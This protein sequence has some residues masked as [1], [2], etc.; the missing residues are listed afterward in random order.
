VVVWKLS[1]GADGSASD[2]DVVPVQTRCARECEASVDLGNDLPVFVNDIIAYSRAREQINALNA[3]LLNGD[4]YP[5]DGELVA[6]GGADVV[7]ALQHNP[8]LRNP[9]MT[10]ILDRVNAVGL[11]RHVDIARHQDQVVVGVPSVDIVVTSHVAATAPLNVNTPK[12]PLCPEV[13]DDPRD[14][15]FDTL[16]LHVAGHVW[17]HI[18]ENARNEVKARLPLGNDDLQSLRTRQR[19]V[20]VT[21]IEVVVKGLNVLYS[22]RLGKVIILV[23]ANLAIKIV[24]VVREEMTSSSLVTKLEASVQASEASSRQKVFSRA[25][26]FLPTLSQLVAV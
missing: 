24:R 7:R 15:I 16:T 25:A 10:D 3:F 21:E 6:G 12:S 11:E 20:V 22:Y 19:F 9:D 26:A 8:Q 2:G 18:L 14:W 23:V 13:C 1:P 17:I 4:G 5:F